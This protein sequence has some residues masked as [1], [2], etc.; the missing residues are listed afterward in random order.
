MGRDRRSEK[1]WSWQAPCWR[2][3]CTFRGGV[4]GESNR[5][6]HVEATVDFVSWT[7]LLTTNPATGTFEFADPAGPMAPGRFYR[8]RIGP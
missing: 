8:A 2:P 1:R 3:N 4:T 7:L 5:R 6:Y